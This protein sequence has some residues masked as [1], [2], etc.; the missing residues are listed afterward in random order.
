M[1]ELEALPLEPRKPARLS[2]HIRLGR[3]S[4][5]RV[6]CLCCKILRIPNQL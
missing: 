3:V 5:E 4:G 2:R 6:S 1:E